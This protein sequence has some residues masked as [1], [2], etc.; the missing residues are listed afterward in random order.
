[1]AIKHRNKIILGIGLGMFV[2]LLVAG[3]FPR[4]HPFSG[5]KG[6]TLWDW[7]SLAGVPLVLAWFGFRLQ[8]QQ[9]QQTKEQLETERDIAEQNRQE[10]V[11]QN[12][13]D[14]VSALLVEKNLLAIATK[15]DTATP[16]EKE[17]YNWR[18]R[19]IFS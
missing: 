9:Q 8:L 3:Y 11:L 19:S 6:K 1:M 18:R 2:A 4:A 5:F 7:L 16:E 14:R 10:E 17:L 12:Y 13:F 15:G